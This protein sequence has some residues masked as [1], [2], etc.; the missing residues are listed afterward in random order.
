MLKVCVVVDVEDFISFKQGNP[1]WNSWQRF[2]GKINNLIKYLRYDKNGFERIY[3][4]VVKERFPISFMVVGSI[5]K[6]KRKSPKFIDWG[7]HTLNH[8]PLTLIRDSELEQ[9]IKN[10]FGAISFSAPMWMVED[11]KNP[12]RVFKALKKQGY[13]ITIYR[14]RSNGIKNEH[15]NRI[16]KP[17]TK[18]GIKCLYTSEW[19]HGETRKK[20]KTIIKEVMSNSEKDAVYC[21]TTHDFSNKNLKNFEF[22]IKKLKE[23]QDMGM[24]KI[25]NLA[26]I[27]RT[28]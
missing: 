1:N 23:M 7:Y 9:E 28:S 22:L 2:K 20:M 12:S 3:K 26:E 13:K 18:Y 4:L 15:E 10:I 11:A 27:A 14:G 8:K 5:F 16:S 19:F 6:P 24:I 21:L 25:M 17:I